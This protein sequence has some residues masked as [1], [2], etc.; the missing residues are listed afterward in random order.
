MIHV[1]VVVL[2]VIV[3]VGINSTAEEKEYGSCGLEEGA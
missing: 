1:E 3:K 2:L